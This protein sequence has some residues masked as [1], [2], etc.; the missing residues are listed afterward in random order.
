MNK[1]I[2]IQ[3]VA[4]TLPLAVFAAEPVRKGGERQIYR[5]SETGR[6]VWRM[7]VSQTN[8]KHCY[9]SEQPWSPDMKKIL[10]SVGQTT[11]QSKVGSI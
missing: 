1:C 5:D 6:T 3:M 7:T 11:D 10:F 4:L 8:D 2:S 9:Y